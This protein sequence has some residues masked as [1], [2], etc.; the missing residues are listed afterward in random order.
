[1]ESLKIDP[2]K[3]KFSP[4]EFKSSITPD[5]TTYTHRFPVVKYKNRT[6]VLECE[7]TI[8]GETGEV[9]INVFDINRNA[10]APF[11]HVPCG[12]Y[13]VILDKIYKAINSELKRLGLVKNDAA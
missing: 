1:M 6:T 9:I 8:D 5:G 11:Y 10:Y 3:Y 7:L 12:N 4:K 13:S 2:S